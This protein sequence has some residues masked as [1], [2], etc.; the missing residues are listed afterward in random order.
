MPAG[1]GSL[2]VQSYSRIVSSIYGGTGLV[3]A[4][5]KVQPVGDTSSMVLVFAT[6]IDAPALGTYFSSVPTPNPAPFSPYD[7][8]VDVVPDPLVLISG[9]PP[10]NSPLS[11]APVRGTIF[12]WVTLPLFGA[13]KWALVFVDAAGELNERLWI[14]TPDELSIVRRNPFFFP[15]G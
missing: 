6:E 5:W 13:T 3:G 4:P 11:L 2:I 7:D 15:D 9:F 14:C 10:A 8:L 1:I 12:Q